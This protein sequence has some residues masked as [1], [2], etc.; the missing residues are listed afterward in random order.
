[1][2]DKRYVSQIH[3]H[4]LTIGEEDVC[5]FVSEGSVFEVVNESTNGLELK[6]NFKI[7][8]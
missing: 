7:L 6:T 5:G 3:K 8:Q 1:M 2:N 4:N